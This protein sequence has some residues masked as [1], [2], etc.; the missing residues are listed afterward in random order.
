LTYNL[1]AYGAMISDR[2]RMDAYEEAL[3]RVVSPSSLVLDIGAGPGIMTLLAAKL[4]ARKVIAVDPNPLVRIGARLAA[5][6][7]VA[8]RVVFVQGR[9]QQIELNE[10]ADVIVADLRGMLPNN[11][12]NIDAI[13]DAR[14]RLLKPDGVLIP[15]TDRLHVAPVQAEAAYEKLLSPWREAGLGLQMRGGAESVLNH[16]IQSLETVDQALGRAEVL[17]TINYRTTESPDF[18]ARLHSEIECAGVLHGFSIW[19]EAELL[20]GITFSTAPDGEETIY[21]RAFLPLPKPE[22]VDAG[23]TLRVEI[24]AKRDVNSMIWIWR[25]KIEA[26]SGTPR[27]SFAMSSVF[28]NPKSPDVLDVL[29]QGCRPSLDEEGVLVR[30]VLNRVDGQRDVG[31]I[32]TELSENHPRRF[33]HEDDAADFVRHVLERNGDC[34][35]RI[36]W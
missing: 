24:R 9:S 26:S 10:K 35:L 7:S 29:R 2:V 31:E 34:I 15:Q 11:P 36:E 17:A 33:P 22:E 12:L 18:S 28:S 27:A 4:G 25:G 1:N 19:F 30:E 32:A 3:R 8:D 16:G 6:N 5:E 21:G 14:Q 23:D 20:P 13:V